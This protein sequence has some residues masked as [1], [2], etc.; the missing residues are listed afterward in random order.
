VKPLRDRLLVKRFEYKNPYIAVVGVELQKGVVIATGYGRRVRRKVRFDNKMGGLSS[1]GA[2]YFED[3]EETGK[4]LP[5]KVKV[6]DVV[7][8][9]PRNQIEWEF[10]G[11]RLVWVW[12]NACY[13]TTNDSQS[14][15][16]L[17]QQSA[18]HDRRGNFMSGADEYAAG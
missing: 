16:L 15:A 18:G 8:F 14:E 2:M 10:E 1:A 9:S 11:E 6:G 4:V 13:G 3:G 5:M 7:E 17:W 12:Q